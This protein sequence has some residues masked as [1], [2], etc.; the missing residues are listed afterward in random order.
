MKYFPLLILTLLVHL[1]QAQLPVESLSPRLKYHV[2]YLA[3]DSLQGR[4]TGSV[5]EQKAANYLIKNFMELGLQPAGDK[6]NW[7]QAFTFTGRQEFGKENSLQID[8][9]K[10]KWLTAWFTLPQSASGLVNGDLVKVGF[11]ITNK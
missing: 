6:G 8:G 5:G 1:A 3:D 11:G 2:Y 10:Q 7:R 9:K 4:Q